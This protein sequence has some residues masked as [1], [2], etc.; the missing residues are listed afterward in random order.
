MERA[1]ANARALRTGRKAEEID[2]GGRKWCARC[3]R[4]ILMWDVAQNNQV[5]MTERRRQQRRETRACARR[6][7]AAQPSHDL[8][9][10][11][12]LMVNSY[13]AWESRGPLAGTAQHAPWSKGDRRDCHEIKPSQAK[14]YGFLSRTRRVQEQVVKR[15]PHTNI[16][17]ESPTC[18]P[19]PPCRECRKLSRVAPRLIADLLDP[20][21]RD[22]VVHELVVNGKDAHSAS[23]F[24][25]DVKHEIRPS[26]YRTNSWI[27]EMAGA[28][29]VAIE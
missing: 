20:N 12:S 23:D 22:A 17:T 9:G 13:L 16:E 15:R 28:L 10:S 4:A 29:P 5:A 1:T 11:T 2:T 7:M 8:L 25:L 3:W 6:A 26:L 14:I 19:R 27:P 21:P 18:S 24:S